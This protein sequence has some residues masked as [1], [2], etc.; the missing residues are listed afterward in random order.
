MSTQL[1][2]GL[3]LL[4]YLLSALVQINDPDPAIW[5]ALYLAA[6]YRPP[7]NQTPSMAPHAM[8]AQSFPTP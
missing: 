7:I 4:A 5:I 1:L 3:F 8:A 6:A 2:N